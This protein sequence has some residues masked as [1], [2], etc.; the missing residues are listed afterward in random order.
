MKTNHLF[1]EKL[2]RFTEHNGQFAD[3]IWKIGFIILPLLHDILKQEIMKKTLV[4][5]MLIASVVAMTCC[6]SD[7]PFQEYYNNNEWNNGS[8]MSNGNSA[9]TGELAS[10]D[11]AIDKTT[12]EPALTQFFLCF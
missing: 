9:T 12:A 10:F 1:D 8:N 3:F 6:T 7:D 5:A 2:I 4:F 11:V